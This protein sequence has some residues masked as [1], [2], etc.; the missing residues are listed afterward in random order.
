M[1]EESG[2]RFTIM[3]AK[4]KAEQ[5][6]ISAVALYKEEEEVT[7]VIFKLRPADCDLLYN[8]QK[9]KACSAYIKLV[10]DTIF[11]LSDLRNSA[12]CNNICR[13]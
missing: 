1:E 2:C 6:S 8:S 13:Q 3:G 7:T 4:D 11:F 9:T 12:F 10:S 5:G